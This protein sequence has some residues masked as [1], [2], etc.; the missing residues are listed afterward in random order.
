[1]YLDFPIKCLLKLETCAFIGYRN[2][3]VELFICFC[4]GTCHFGRTGGGVSGILFEAAG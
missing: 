1:M 3:Y 4:F 2:L